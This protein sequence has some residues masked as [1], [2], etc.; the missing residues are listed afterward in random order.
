[1][2]TE[3]TVP[4]TKYEH[5]SACPLISDHATVAEEF[6]E[7]FRELED[8]APVSVDWGAAGC[9]TCFNTDADI[10]VYWVAQNDAVD[11]MFIGYG[12]DTLPAS[13]VAGMVQQAASNVGVETSWAGDT[14]K[15]VC[16]GSDDY[17][18]R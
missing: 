17:Y 16:L 15:T 3:T 10:G 1:M 18:P 8:L 7:V 5:E 9:G 12:S 6:I 13:A 11:T 4:A 14:S 2:Q